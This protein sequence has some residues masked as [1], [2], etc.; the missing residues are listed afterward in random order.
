MGLCIITICVILRKSHCSVYQRIRQFDYHDY[1]YLYVII[2]MISVIMITIDAITMV[3]PMSMVD[4]ISALPLSR[5][6]PATH[7]E[8]IQAGVLQLVG[9]GTTRMGQSDT[10]LLGGHLR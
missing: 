4:S 8:R 3:H 10:P 6:P 7:G 9:Q 1:H 5:S 2:L